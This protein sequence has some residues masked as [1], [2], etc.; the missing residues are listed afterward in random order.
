MVLGYRQRTRRKFKKGFRQNGAIRMTNYLTK[1]RKGD[2]VDIVVDSAIHKG[3]PH[4]Q[5]HGKTGVV[6]NLNKRAVGVRL[7][8]TVRH[9]K[10][11]KF[12]HVR[13][14]HIRHSDSRKNFL[15]RCRTND[16][17]KAEANKKG[18]KI[19]TKRQVKGPSAEKT[20]AF[21]IEAIDY[22]VNKP[23]IEFH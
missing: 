21:D 6:Y 4:H 9:R 3:M 5:Y 17:L 7:L 11:E 16:A 22:R 15:E 23:F 2:I 18:E 19:S 14:E 1:F 13:V 10:I 8:K 20:V 12:L